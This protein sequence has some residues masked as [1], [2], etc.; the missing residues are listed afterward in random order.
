MR[1]RLAPEADYYRLPTP[2]QPA[3]QPEA[4]AIC[5]VQVIPGCTDDHWANVQQM[6]ELAF[7]MLSDSPRSPRD[8]GD[9]YFWN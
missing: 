2:Q 3:M 5:S 6:Y 1:H 7:A 8:V 9:S 4:F